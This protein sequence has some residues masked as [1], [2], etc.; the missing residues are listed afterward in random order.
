MTDVNT[1]LHIFSPLNFIE[2]NVP[3]LF[4]FFFAHDV[5]TYLDNTFI[6]K[7]QKSTWSKYL[8][9]FHLS[10]KVFHAHINLYHQFQRNICQRQFTPTHMVVWIVRAY[11]LRK[12]MR[13][14]FEPMYVLLW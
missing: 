10:K 3:L 1:R 6:D 2:A 8:F 4:F 14:E 5:S 11:V 7:W 9:Y 13:K 12:E